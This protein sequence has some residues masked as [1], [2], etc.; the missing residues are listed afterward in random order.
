MTMKRA[1]NTATSKRNGRLVDVC[2]ALPS[3][4]RAVFIFGVGCKKC[5]DEQRMMTTAR[6]AW[7]FEP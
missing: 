4:K 6:A 1:D 2:G 3:G 5:E 7:N